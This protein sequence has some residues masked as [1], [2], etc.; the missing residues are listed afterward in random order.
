M[1]QLA[2]IKLV[3]T[4]SKSEKRNF[5]M[6]AKKQAGP[7]DY[8]KLFDLIDGLETAD[9]KNLK[10]KYCQLHPGSSM[11]NA[12]QYLMKVLTDCL[13][14]SKVEKDIFFHSMQ[15][16]LRARVLHE[17]SLP[18]ESYKQLKKV[19]QLPVRYQKPALWID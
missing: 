8:L 15:S 7:K 2:V 14:Q 18:E 13:I 11:D 6:Q 9:I 3:K 16:L 1:S 5:K 19:R 17:R 10:E 4:L 12:L